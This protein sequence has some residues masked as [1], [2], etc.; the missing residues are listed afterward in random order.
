[1]EVAVK[2]EILRFVKD[3]SVLEGGHAA[4]EGGIGAIHGKVGRVLTHQG[5]QKGAR[6]KALGKR[7]QDRDRVLAMGR[8][9]Q[10]AH[11]HAA[12]EHSVGIEAGR[13]HLAEHFGKRGERNLEIV[14]RARIGRGK[15]RIR[16]LEIGQIDVHQPVKQAERFHAFVA[17]AIVDDGDPE[18]GS[19]RAQNVNQLKR[20]GRGRDQIDVVG[21]L[22]A[23]TEHELGEAIR[24]D[25]LSQRVVAHFAVL[26]KHAPQI[27]SRKKDRPRPV[28]A[29]DRGLL[30]LVERG[31]R[32][33]ELP[34]HAAIA[35]LPRRAVHAA[36]ARAL[37]TFV[38]H[39]KLPS[40]HLL[41]NYYSISPRI[42]QAKPKLSPHV[43]L[44]VG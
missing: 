38:F 18:L 7:A 8:K 44:P 1:M 5:E 20:I 24:A 34:R 28:F 17:A 2:A 3:G 25:G 4:V 39:L 40:V 9:H 22:V 43:C 13:A 16:I 33:R 15:R 36:P 32:H 26:T 27:A 19:D 37:H 6:A 21:A 23:Q 12:K 29:A 35:K 11:D 14:P 30:P 42:L 41:C 31:A 10:M